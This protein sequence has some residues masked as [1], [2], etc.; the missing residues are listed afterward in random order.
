METERPH[1]IELI[2]LITESEHHLNNLCFRIRTLASTWL[3]ATFAA[4]GFVL[5]KEGCFILKKSTLVILLCWAG[6]I[7]IFVLWI[8]DLQVYQKLLHVW[9]EVRKEIEE[10]N[11]YLPQIREKMRT[12]MHGGRASDLIKIFYMVMIAA[13]L[14]FALTLSLSL[15]LN[16]ISIWLFLITLFLLLAEV[17][18]IFYL[19]PRDHSNR[20]GSD[21]K[22]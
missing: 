9:F 7:G 19:T 13:P 21:K 8:L 2:R 22:R 3:L 1:T 18:L 17:I 10:E 12:A 6:A 16:A 14:S 4:A 20:I 5:T 15:S 11:S